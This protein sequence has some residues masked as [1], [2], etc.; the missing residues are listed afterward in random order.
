M[1]NRLCCDGKRQF[2]NSLQYWELNAWLKDQRPEPF[3]SF[4]STVEE[5]ND[6]IGEPTQAELERAEKIVAAG[7]FP[8]NEEDEK[9]LVPSGES[10]K[11]MIGRYI[12]HG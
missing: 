10:R 12:K 7:R 8:L 2:E 5:M 3:S 6:I 4:P 11:E 9:F 1:P